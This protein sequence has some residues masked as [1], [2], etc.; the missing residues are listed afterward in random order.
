MF[1]QPRYARGPHGTRSSYL[2]LLSLS[3]FFELLPASAPPDTA[4]Y[5][6]QC[7]TVELAT[8]VEPELGGGRGRQ[9]ALYM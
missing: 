6:V 9:R 4:C 1:L 5:T 8:G 3:N 2:P 7:A